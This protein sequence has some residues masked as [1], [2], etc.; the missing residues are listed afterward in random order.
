MDDGEQLQR[1]LKSGDKQRAKETASAKKERS[2]T[3]KQH[4]VFSSSTY[5]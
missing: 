4:S 3:E 1:L 5:G 2:R